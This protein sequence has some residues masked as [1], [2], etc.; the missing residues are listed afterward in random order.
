MYAAVTA[1]TAGVTW[2]PRALPG[3][4]EYVTLLVGATFLLAAVRLARRRPGGMQQM[5]I[6]L[7]GLLEPPDADDPRPPGPLGLYDLARALRAALPSGA[8]ETAIALAVAAVVFPPFVLGYVYWHQPAHPFVFRLPAD[9][10]ELAAT[11]LLVIAL[12]E[13]V[14]FRGYVQTR[15]G[16]RFTS[17]PRWLGGLVDPR[18]LVLS[19]ALFAAIHFVSIRDPER[20]AVFF[21]GLLFGL[22]RAWRGGVGAAILLH[23]LSNLLAELLQRGFSAPP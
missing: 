1:I 4:T 6:A 17:R 14:F 9:F 16:D 19:A 10:A 22:L 15:L 11:H 23:A 21:P 5:G 7:G 13:E 8:R 12:P 3:M 20:L 18:A 2:L